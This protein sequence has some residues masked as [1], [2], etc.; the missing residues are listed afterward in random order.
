[1]DL[2]WS[3]V[4]VF[5]RDGRNHPYP[6]PALQTL[7][8]ENGGSPILPSWGPLTPS[9][10]CRQF[11]NVYLP[12]EL[13]PTTAVCHLGAGHW[14]MTLEA[15]MQ[16]L[17]AKVLEAWSRG[18]RLRKGLAEPQSMAETASTPEWVLR[19]FRAPVLG[20]KSPSCYRLPLRWILDEKDK[21]GPRATPNP[22]VLLDIYQSSLQAF[23]VTPILLSNLSAISP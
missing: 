14:D 11:G 10:R 1:M 19:G 23:S 2:A 13:P 12:S 3:L 5:S 15:D 7:D 18:H 4:Q 8:V 21:Y 6:C 16:G 20:F 17:E 22:G 9:T